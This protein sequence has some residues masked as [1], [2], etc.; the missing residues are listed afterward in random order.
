MQWKNSASKYG[1]VSKTFHWLIF[2]LVFVMIVGGFFLDDVPDEYKGTIYNLHKLTGLCI[3]LLMV[4]RMLW[5]SCNVKPALPASMPHWQQVSAR[6]THYL[7]YLLVTAM[8]LVGWIGS[9]ASRKAP[10]LGSFTFTLPVPEDKALSHALFDVHEVIAYM[11][12]AV[13]CL[14][15]AAA[16]YHHYVKKDDVLRRMLSG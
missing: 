10:H 14:H 9:S 8:P 16:L 15:I 12:I 13:V 5:A 4:L 3:L 6:V 11:I 1:V 2:V 7:L